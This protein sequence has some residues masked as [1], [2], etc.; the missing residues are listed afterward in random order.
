MIVEP[1]ALPLKTKRLTLRHYRADDLEQTLAYHG[2]PD[3][4]RYLLE[5]PWTREVA[6]QQ[7]TRRM[8]R[9]HIGASDQALALVV[10]HDGSV[11][12][13]V[14]L[15]PTDEWLRTAE[16]G[17]AFHPAAQGKGYATEAVLALIDLAFGHY[18]MHRVKAQLDARNTASARVCERLGMSREA[19]L[20]RDWWS[21][22]E[23][24]DTLVYGMLAGESAR[25]FQ[26]GTR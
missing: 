6:Q 22:G 1:P 24:S 26:P 9:K 5:P 13:D 7:I 8:G 10:E 19:H 2:D 11:I 21:K 25:D 18:G 16:L 20:R 23:W 12:G 14:G 4:A 17:W 3:V 15:W